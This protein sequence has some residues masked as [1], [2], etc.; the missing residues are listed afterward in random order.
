L[1]PEDR[2]RDCFHHSSA[3]FGGSWVLGWSL[4]SAA[5]ERRPPAEDCVGNYRK[6]GR[7]ETLAK[8]LIAERRRQVNSRMQ[9]QRRWPCERTQMTQS[10]G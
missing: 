6:K 9:R 7:V 4:L 10:L 3:F 8:R 1:A 5:R 2:Q